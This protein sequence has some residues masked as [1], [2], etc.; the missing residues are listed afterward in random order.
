MIQRTVI[1]WIEIDQTVKEKRLLL[2]SKICL[3]AVLLTIKLT[4]VFI[5][6]EIYNCQIKPINPTAT[7][8]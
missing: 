5:V 4:A 2:V 3:P 8:K 7:S 6:K 1:H